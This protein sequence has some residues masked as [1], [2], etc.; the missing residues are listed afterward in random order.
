MQ[1]GQCVQKVLG[2]AAFVPMLKDRE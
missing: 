1:D 2:D